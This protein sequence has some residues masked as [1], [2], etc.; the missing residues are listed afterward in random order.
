MGFLTAGSHI[1]P[2]YCKLYIDEKNCPLP[3]WFASS[4]A[5]SSWSDVGERVCGDTD[6]RTV[7]YVAVA[8][9]LND[10]TQR[11]L[12]VLVAGEVECMGGPRSHHGDV[13]APQRSEDPLRLDD[14][15]QG[16][17]H[18]L[19]LCIGVRLQTLHPCLWN[20]II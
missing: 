13:E 19:V 11:V 6:A 7:G 4:T 2:G 10:V 3:G 14:P 9:A 12:D 18:A 17:I 5:C 8:S 16:F 1:W 20:K 15:F